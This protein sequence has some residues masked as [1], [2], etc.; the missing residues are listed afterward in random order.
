[1]KK[2][3]ITV[4]SLVLL[5]S[6]MSDDKL[7]DYNKDPK[8]PT[9]VEADF[10]FNAATKSLV[11]QMTNTSVNLNVYRL[12]AQYWTETTYIDEANYNLTE[13]NIPQSHWS[14]LYRD[15]LLDLATAK[16]YVMTDPD[17]LE[18]E[19][20]ARIAQAEV[21]SI[22][23]W[24]QLV[25]TFGNI[26]YT[27]ALNAEEFILPAYDDAA[28]IYT[29]L[30]ARIDVAI[31]DLGNGSGFGID[32]LYHGD[33]VAWQKFA[34]SLKL[35]LGIRLADVDPSVAQ[36][37]V[38]SAYSAGVFSSNADNASFVYLGT[39]NPNPVW[40]SLVQSGRSDFIVANTVV[41]FMND[42]NDP[43]RSTYFDD[44]LGEG[45][46]EGGPYGDNNGFSSY[47]H[48][49]DVMHDPVNP[50][51]LMDFAE[52][53]F[54]LAEAAARGWSVGGTAE[55]HYNN[56]ITASFEY[57]GVADVVT[58]LA[59]PAVDYATASGDWKEKIGNQ[60]WL[61]MYNR[62]FEGWT[63]WRK[64]DTP[65]FNLPVNTGN[66][67]PTRYTYPVNEQNLNKVNWEAASTAIGGDAQ[68]TKL[69]WD[70]N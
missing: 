68:T 35:R 69:F 13:R 15:V 19:K 46:Y 49:G 48:I 27:E 31:S 61:A 2:V 63:V 39:S 53:S 44:N 25:D 40:S 34:I 22:Y 16:E 47:T 55:E 51:C 54:Y 45:I 60:F 8:N 50:T 67:V 65:T 1:M 21:L 56:G 4:F 37:T 59:D 43:R 52:V 6:C 58:Y 30:L 7:E 57:W 70:V 17:L 18:A 20:T 28:S 9:E 14:E 41:D 3:F 33:L 29:D 66:P 10:L 42:L 5:S 32:N 62:G 64:F 36:T 12:L 23:T 24:Q 26:P 11:D 38:E